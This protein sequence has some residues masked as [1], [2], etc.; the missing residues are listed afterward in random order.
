M[1]KNIKVKISDKFWSPKLKIFR[2]VTLPDTL[3]KLERDGA[4]ENFNKVIVGS[5][6]H[7]IC[8]WHDGLLHE[9][10][11]GAADYL[12]QERNEVIA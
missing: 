10:I 9:T 4:V 11:R 2:E 12:A 3:N 6:R 7:E 5:G 8:P 1:Q